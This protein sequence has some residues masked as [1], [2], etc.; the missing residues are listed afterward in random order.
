MLSRHQAREYVNAVA[1]DGEVVK[2]ATVFLAPVFHHPDATTLGTVVGRQFLQA[3]YPVATL[4]TVLS[5]D[6]VVRSS[7][8]N[9]V[10]S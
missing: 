7:S 2:A 1:H 8:S 6:S 5:R 4:C 3:N 9:T 10:A